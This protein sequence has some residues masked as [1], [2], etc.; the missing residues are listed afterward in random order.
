MS[1]ISF[2]N[3]VQ[4]GIHRGMSRLVAWIN[5]APLYRSS[6]RAMPTPRL[7]Q[8]LEARQKRCKF[9]HSNDSNS[10]NSVR[11]GNLKTRGRR[12]VR[13]RTDRKSTRCRTTSRLE[14][15]CGNE[16]DDTREKFNVSACFRVKKFTFP[17]FLKN[18]FKLPQFA[19]S[20]CSGPPVLSSRWIV[21][22]R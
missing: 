20:L 8:P 22:G 16:W 18:K 21:R 6:R 10:P 17:L 4:Q 12:S 7:E 19:F 2:S 13:G 11:T 14:S 9:S 3:P 5:E 15:A 1:H